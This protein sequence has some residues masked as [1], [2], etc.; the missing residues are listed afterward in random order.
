M[1]KR[2]ADIEAAADARIRDGTKDLE[3]LKSERSAEAKNAAEAAKAQAER[4]KQMSEKVVGLEKQIADVKLASERRTRHKD[5]EIARIKAEMNDRV[6]DSEELQLGRLCMQFVNSVCRTIVESAQRDPAFT[7]RSRIE[8][9]GRLLVAL[10]T[11]NKVKGETTSFFC[12]LG[13]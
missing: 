6:R 9:A 3:R 8:Y 12:R 4:D 10:D 13:F 5:E 7:D 2:V 1:L 11:Y